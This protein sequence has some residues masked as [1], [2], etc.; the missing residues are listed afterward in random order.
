MVVLDSE[1]LSE[2]G[3]KRKIPLPLRVVLSKTSKKI[4]RIE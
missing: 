3:Y 4:E 2:F 1:T